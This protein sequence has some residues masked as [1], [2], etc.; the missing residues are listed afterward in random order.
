MLESD[1][2]AAE[3]REFYDDAYFEAFAAGTL[4]TLEQRLND[5]IAAVAAMITGAWEA[6]G[7]AGVPTEAAANSAAVFAVQ[8]RS[9]LETSSRPAMDVYL[10]PVGP[11][12]YECYY[13]AAE[14][15]ETDEPVEGA[16]LLRAHARASSTSS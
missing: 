14:Q 5:S 8:T 13:E 4:P 12:R 7:P 11:D 10:V 2:K 3:G 15:D 16:G 9:E 1:K 6:G